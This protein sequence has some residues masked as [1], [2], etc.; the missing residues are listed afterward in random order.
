MTPGRRVANST[1]EAVR[2]RSGLGAWE[3]G[4]ALRSLEERD[5]PLVRQD[6]DEGLGVC[7]WMSTYEAAEATED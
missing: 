5:P 3:P 2:E 1:T 6:V 7:F 4:R